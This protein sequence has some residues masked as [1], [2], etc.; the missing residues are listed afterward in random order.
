MHYG[1]LSAANEWHQTRGNSAWAAGSEEA[2]TAALVRASDWL[3]ATYGPRFKG[4]PSTM[5][6]PREWPRIGVCLRGHEL[7]DDEVP[8]Q[9][10]AAVYD[11][12]LRELAAPGSLAPDFDPAA[13]IRAK[14]EGLGPMQE[15]YTYAA[16]ATAGEARKAFPIIEG[17]LRPFLTGSTSNFAVRW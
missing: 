3:D 12:A 16:P 8:S 7:P 9:I 6:Q 1:T 2:R 5:S 15:S 10:L 17:Y 11:A 14:S 4:Q 13:Q